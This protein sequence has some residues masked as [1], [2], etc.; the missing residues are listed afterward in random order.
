MTLQVTGL[1]R[2]IFAQKLPGHPEFEQLSLNIFI[3]ILLITLLFSLYL[4]IKGK[5]DKQKSLSIQLEEKLAEY[6]LT[7]KQKEITKLILKGKE[8]K[9][10]SKIM[11]V[12]ENTIKSHKQEIFRKIGVS[13][14]FELYK[15]LESAG[16]NSRDKS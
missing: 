11:K 3:E 16:N 6:H 15:K 5:Q 7:P 1:H 8:P 2:I 4:Y 13:S 10:I 12:T 9:E 14:I